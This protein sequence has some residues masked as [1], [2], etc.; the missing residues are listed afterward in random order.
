MSVALY[1]DHHVPVVITKGLRRRGVDVLTAEEDG[2]TTLPDPDLLNRAAAVNRVL[3]TRDKDFLRE[4]AR[5]Q[6]TGETFA[7]VIYAHQQKVPIGRCVNDLEIIA[8]VG[9]AAD[10][11]NRVLYLPL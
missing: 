6:Q 7:G 2:T 4:T 3:F 10:L 5:R 1:M 9:E 8:K 11:G